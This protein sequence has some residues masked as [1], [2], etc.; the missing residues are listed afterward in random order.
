MFSTNR[1]KETFIKEFSRLSD[2]EFEFFYDLLNQDSGDYTYK[3][4]LSEF[5]YKIRNNNINIQAQCEIMRKEQERSKAWMDGLPWTWVGPDG[6]SAC[7]N[8]GFPIIMAIVRERDWLRNQIKELS[9]SIDNLKKEK[10]DLVNSIAKL[11]SQIDTEINKQ[12]KYLQLGFLIGIA[13]QRKR[14]KKDELV[15]NSL[16][17][18]RTA[19]HLEQAQLHQFQQTLLQQAKELDSLKLNYETELLFLQSSRSP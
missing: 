19:L 13:Y 10:D 7:S 9:T 1:T 18:Q 8:R 6:K 4:A 5:H 15:A 2:S 12:K 16:A 17:L 3:Q 14:T 11:Q